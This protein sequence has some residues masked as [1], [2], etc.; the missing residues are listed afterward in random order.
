MAW[1]T[2]ETISGGWSVVRILLPPD[3]WLASIVIGQLSALCYP[4][5]WKEVGD[6]TADQAAAV[7]SYAQRTIAVQ[8]S[9]IGQIVCFPY[10]GAQWIDRNPALGASQFRKANGGALSASEYPD[11]FA[12]LGYTFGGSGDLFGLPDL[13]GRTIVHVGQ[14][15]G[16]AYRNLGD[17]FGAEKTTLTINQI[18]AHTHSEIGATAVV[19]NGGLEAPAASAVPVATVTGSAGGGQQHDNMQP[20]IALYY[21]IQVTL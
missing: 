1:N 17:R 7:F 13:R 14:A 4:T 8:A 2:G 20:S 12:A 19:I 15:L 5:A 10:D 16:G 18:P 3:D 21:Y 9:A 6:I 11:L